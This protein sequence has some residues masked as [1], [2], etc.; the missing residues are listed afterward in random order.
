MLLRGLT[1]SFLFIL[2]SIYVESFLCHAMCIFI[3]QV[4][5]KTTLIIG[6]FFPRAK[7][8]AEKVRTEKN[9]KTILHTVGTLR[10]KL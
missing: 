9:Y 7:N 1:S 6:S 10:L 8:V 5:P 2:L 4:L 3:Q